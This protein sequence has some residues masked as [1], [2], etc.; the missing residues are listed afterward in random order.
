M[1]KY[2]IKGR[3]TTRQIFRKLFG[4]GLLIGLVAGA[5]SSGLE[6]AWMARK[7]PHHHD[8]HGEEGHAHH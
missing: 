6:R 4:R 3:G 8:G 2:T 1:W 7:Y 5:V